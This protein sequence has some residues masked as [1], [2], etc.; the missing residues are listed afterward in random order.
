MVMIIG[1]YRYWRLWIL[2][3]A[4]LVVLELGVCAPCPY[5][6][7]SP[8]ASIFNLFFSLE[9]NFGVELGNTRD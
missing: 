8:E 1:A 2:A 4:A 9:S 3:G 7:G 5:C 6:V